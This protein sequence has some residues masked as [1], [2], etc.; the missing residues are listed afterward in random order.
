MVSN[1]LPHHCNDLSGLIGIVH[2]GLCRVRSSTTL[3]YFVTFYL[4]AM[5]FV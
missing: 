5:V 3:K 4:N 2:R 1:I